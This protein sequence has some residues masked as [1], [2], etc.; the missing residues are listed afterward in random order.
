MLAVLLRRQAS[1]APAAAS[2][3]LNLNKQRKPCSVTATRFFLLRIPMCYRKRCSVCGKLT[4]G[5]CG[6]H[7]EI[8]LGDVPQDQRCGGHPIEEEDTAD[9]D[10]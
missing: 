7:I 1:V 10:S 5:G 2:D 4:Y 6:K 8:V 3:K 9:D